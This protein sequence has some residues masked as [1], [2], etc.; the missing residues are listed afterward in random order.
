MTV[1]IN[2][3]VCAEGGFPIRA[4]IFPQLTRSELLRN[5]QKFARSPQV[6]VAIPGGRVVGGNAPGGSTRQFFLVL[7]LFCLFS[8]DS[9]MPAQ[10]DLG[11]LTTI[12]VEPRSN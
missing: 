8:L 2:D 10:G 5:H 12:S 11:L 9:V 1:F 7:F 4:G 3:S 6:T